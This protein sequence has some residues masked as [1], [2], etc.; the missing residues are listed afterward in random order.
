MK[1]LEGLHIEGRRW[2]QRSYGNTYHTVRIY[3]NGELLHATEQQ[4]GYDDQYIQ[5]ALDWLEANGYI[6][7]KEYPNGSKEGGT[8]YLRET[9]HGTNTV[10]DVTRE[11]DL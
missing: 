5:T 8:L 2:F 7:R 4:Y 10:I 9:L 6:E 11:R 3:A 1:T